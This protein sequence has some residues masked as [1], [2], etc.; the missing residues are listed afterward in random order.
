MDTPANDNNREGEEEVAGTGVT[1]VGATVFG[2]P[3]WPRALYDFVRV[4][5]RDG[6][7]CERLGVADFE[8]V[9]MPEG[10]TAAMFV[11]DVLVGVEAHGTHTQFLRVSG[12]VRKPC[13]C[14]FICR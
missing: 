11:G 2:H 1:A 5:D 12:I 13:W 6:W 10:S 4:V 9:G 8:I 7:V 14:C 3:V